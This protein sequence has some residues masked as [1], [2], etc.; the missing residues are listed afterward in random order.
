LGG[1]RAISVTA[2][3]RTGKNA[4]V[5]EKTAQAI[6]VCRAISVAARIRTGNIAKDTCA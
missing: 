4:I 2:E 1:F 6:N 3:F 5:V